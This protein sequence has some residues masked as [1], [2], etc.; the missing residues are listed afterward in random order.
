MLGM[1]VIAPGAGAALQ[2][3]RLFRT[4]IGPLALCGAVQAR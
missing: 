1:L 3:R 4:R 2:L